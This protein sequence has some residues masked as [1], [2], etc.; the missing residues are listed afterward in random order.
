MV[1]DYGITQNHLNLFC[2]NTSVINIS[3]NP[4][5]NSQTKH[6][7]IR[8]HFIRELVEDKVLWIEYVPTND[9]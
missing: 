3:K 2:N 6:I 5:Q 7:V 1:D 8:H 4:V 9:Q